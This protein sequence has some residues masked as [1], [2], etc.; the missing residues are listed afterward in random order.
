MKSSNLGREA[1]EI[2]LIDRYEQNLE[3]LPAHIGDT[4]LPSYLVICPGDILA[5]L[6]NDYGAELLEQ[7]VRSFLQAKAAASA[8]A[9]EIPF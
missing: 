2:D 5:D 3:C 8:K 6:Y 4:A 9:S 7:N 1:L